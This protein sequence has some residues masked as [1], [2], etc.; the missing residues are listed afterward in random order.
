MVLEENFDSEEG[1]FGD[2]GTF[3]REVDMSGLG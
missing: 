2:N 3:F 1:L